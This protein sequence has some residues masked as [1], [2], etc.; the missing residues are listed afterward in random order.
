MAKDNLGEFGFPGFSWKERDLTGALSLGHDDTVE[1]EMQFSG[2][3]ATLL[4]SN[5]ASTAPPQKNYCFWTATCAHLR[6]NFNS[7]FFWWA[8]S[9]WRVWSHVFNLKWWPGV[10]SFY[11]SL[12]L[13]FVSECLECSRGT[14]NTCADCWI[15]GT[16]TFRGQSLCL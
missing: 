3:W 9:E 12:C 5:P 15:S 8:S 2:C 6:I 11:W 10:P 4:L 7:R 16:L 14:L 13:Y 1:A